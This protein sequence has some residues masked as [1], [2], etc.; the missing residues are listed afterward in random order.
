VLLKL[1][2][3]DDRPDVRRD[4]IMDIS[5]LLD[6]FFDMYQDKIWDEHNDL[7]K[8]EESELIAIAAVV[9]GR[10][11]GKI[12]ARNEKLYQRVGKILQENSLT[13]E[14]SAMGLIMTKYFENTAEENVH[15]I[16]RIEVGFLA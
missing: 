9:L 1:I 6:H 3:W 15:L 12:A 4:D 13:A 16:K 11:I 7:F 8:E 14:R 5:E 10:E 2:A